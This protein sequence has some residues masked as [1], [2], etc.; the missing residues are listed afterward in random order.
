MAED[1]AVHFLRQMMRIRLFE[2]RVLR[3]FSRGSLSGTTHTCIGQEANAVG[4]LSAASR[5]DAVFS[6]HRCHGHFLAHGGDMRALAAELMGKATG[7]CGGL[8]GSQHLHWG[9]FSSSGIQGGI[10]PCSTGMA[11][12]EKHKGSGRIALAFLGD[13]TLGE[14]V[15]YESLNLASLWSLPILYVLENNLYAQSTPVAMAVAG[16]IPERFRAFGITTRCLRT[17]DV[18]EV[19]SA[20][21]DL[22]ERVRNG[23]RPAALVIETYR[24]SP[25]SKGDDTRDPAEIERYRRFDPVRV[26]AGKV[27]ETAASA[28]CAECACEVESAFRLAHADPVPD[29]TRCLRPTPEA[30][31]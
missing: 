14:G 27:P 11:L 13:G 12:A 25:H 2:E 28:V 16:A 30:L 10:V 15:V 26:Q 29:L 20:S 6:N 21:E 4:V 19:F 5:A 3:E 22:L 8:G 17:T 1:Q 24:F 31:P 18:E 7:V 23:P 9:T